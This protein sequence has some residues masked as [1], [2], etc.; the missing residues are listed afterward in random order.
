MIRPP[1]P[2]AAQLLAAVRGRLLAQ[3]HSLD[4]TTAASAEMSKAHADGR[5]FEVA[6]AIFGECVV[7][8]D[9][10]QLIRL[11]CEA[12]GYEDDGT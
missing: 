9:A 6:Q 11:A 2:Q 12:L 10:D 1:I 4:P 3:M 7:L 8:F 5:Y